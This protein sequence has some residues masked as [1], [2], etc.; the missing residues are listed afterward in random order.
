MSDL[1]WNQRP[2]RLT[3]AGDLQSYIDGLRQAVS[4]RPTRP[5]EGRHKRDGG[6]VAAERNI[7][8]RVRNEYYSSI[9]PNASPTSERP[10]RALSLIG[11]RYVET[12]LDISP[13]LRWNSTG[14]RYPAP[15]AVLRSACSTAR[16]RVQLTPPTSSP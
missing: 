5:T 6:L 12:V 11:V 10:V 16:R 8:S 1:G 4:T 3:P 9:R 15:S 2:G 13:F 7:L 14:A